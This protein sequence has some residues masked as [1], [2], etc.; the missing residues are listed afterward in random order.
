MSAIGYGCTIT[1][2]PTTGLE[3][4]LVDA[5]VL[6]NS[7]STD[8]VDVTTFASP[9]RAR[10]FIPG[11]NDEGELSIQA[12]FNDNAV[13]TAL[14]A[15]RNAGS[16]LKWVITVDGVAMSFDGFVTGIGTSIPVGDK[17]TR[18]FSVKI[19]GGVTEA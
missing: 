14:L 2:G 3:N 9:G 17:V 1:F 5:F 11:L 13:Q 16:V 12:N 15:A 7:R 18:T 10:E 19:T 6:D 4:S 8:S